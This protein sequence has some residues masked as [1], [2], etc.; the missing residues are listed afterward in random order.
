[1]S[2]IEEAGHDCTGSLSY[3]SYHEQSRPQNDRAGRFGGHPSARMAP[4]WRLATPA[5]LP[6]HPGRHRR[7]A[8][9]PQ[10]APIDPPDAELNRP[11]QR[12]ALV[13]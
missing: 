8:D 5:R 13:D 12:T 1:M 3:P 10:R 6:P 11:V 7:F 4:I 9:Q 2:I